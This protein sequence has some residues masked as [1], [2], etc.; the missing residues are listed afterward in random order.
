MR[1]E[2]VEKALHFDISHDDDVTMTTS[3]G[4][5]AEAQTSSSGVQAEAQTRSSGTQASTR[6]GE[7]E[8]QTGRI[9]TKERGR[10]AIEYR[11]DEIEQL[12]HASESEKQALIDQHAQNV[13]RIRQQ[14]MAEGEAAH[15][16]MKEN[17]NK[18]PL[19]RHK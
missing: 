5:Q 4:V 14:V 8:T 17:I 19:K 18:E 15:I 7:S 3:S 1:A 2:R 10:Q 11:S 16:R 13:E 12:R 9:K 6:M